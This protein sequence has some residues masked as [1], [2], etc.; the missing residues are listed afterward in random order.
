LQKEVVTWSAQQTLT[1]VNLGY[2]VAEWTPFQT[3]YFSEKLVAP[4]IE[5]ETS[6]SVIR[7]PDH[8]TTEAVIYQVS[9]SYKIYSMDDHRE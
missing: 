3:H 7:N 8:Y 2:I 9:Y 5:P 1:A 6:G 4:G